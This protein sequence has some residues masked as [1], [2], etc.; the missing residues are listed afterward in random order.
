MFITTTLSLVRV[1]DGF[2]AIPGWESNHVRLYKT[3][4]ALSPAMVAADFTEADYTGYVA[5]E[6]VPEGA[7]YDD[8]MGNARQALEGLTFRPTGT[9]IT[10]VIYGYYITAVFAGSGEVLVAAQSFPEP[11]TMASALDV[12]QFFPQYVLGQPVAV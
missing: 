2:A 7:A 6:A 10:N 12:L 1:L 11:V 4:V 8:E 3:D 9:T 5:Q